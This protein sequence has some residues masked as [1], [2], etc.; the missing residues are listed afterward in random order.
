MKWAIAGLILLFLFAFSWMYVHP[1]VDWW[2]K[3]T[4]PQDAIAAGQRDILDA[5]D[6]KVRQASERVA[7]KVRDEDLEEAKRIIETEL[8]PAQRA[9]EEAQRALQAP[10]I[11]PPPEA[12]QPR[13]ILTPA[14]IRRSQAHQPD[15]VTSPEPVPSRF[16]PFNS[17]SERRA[18]TVHKISN[19]EA[20]ELYY[21]ALRTKYKDEQEC[22]AK[23]G[24]H[25]TCKDAF[26]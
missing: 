17:A 14:P 21:Q 19:E 2:N 15:Q 4:R 26:K 10:A 16:V 13:S 18:E 22:L 5:L 1:R 23:E 7:A 3:N 20:Q 8:K 9:Y 11:P 25:S 6:L 24:P 12:R